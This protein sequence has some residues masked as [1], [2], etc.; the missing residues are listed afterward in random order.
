[1]RLSA[2]D[3]GGEKHALLETGGGSIRQSCDEVLATLVAKAGFEK[4]L[5]RSDRG[6][7]KRSGIGDLR[8]LN[9]LDDLGGELRSSVDDLRSV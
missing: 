8:C 1:M 4:T 6:S 2:V 3:L 7:E 5:G 9:D